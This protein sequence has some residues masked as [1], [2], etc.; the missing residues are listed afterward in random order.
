MKLF[1]KSVCVSRERFSVKSGFAGFIENKLVLVYE[2]NKMPE[3]KKIGFIGAG[4]M[5]VAIIKGLINSGTV[6]PENITAS[7]LFEERAKKV[8]EEI[9]IK[10]VKDNQ[11]VVK[12]AD[13]IVLCTK[14][15]VVESVLTEV[16]ELISPEKLI[17]SIAAGVSTEFM[18]NIIGN[19]AQVIR[20]MPNTPALVNEGM[21]AV[22]RGKN[23]DEKSVDFAVNLFKSIGRCIEVPE[24]LIGAVTGISGS[25]PAFIFLMIEALADGGVKL[26][27]T[28][29]TAI[30]LAA[31]TCLGAAKMVLETG[32]HPSLLK[33]EVTT[34][35]GCTIAG[36]MVMENEGVRSALSKTVVETAK[37]SMGLGK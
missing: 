17:I 11:S 14:P 22:C 28:K 15:Y 3:A 9:G 23:V 2:E 18:E 37:V 10:V 36:L 24:K 27:L 5:A 6:S 13:V 20:V 33:D 29:Q 31:Q 12:N 7:E 21:S 19:K 8:S 34:P 4:T 25:G 30:E 26:G 32:K 1:T 16:K 35:G